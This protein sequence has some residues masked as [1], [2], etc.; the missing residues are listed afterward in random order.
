MDLPCSGNY[1]QRRRTQRHC[2]MS[3]VH[4]RES[5]VTCLLM[6]GGVVQVPQTTIHW[7]LHLSRH[8]HAR[9]RS[10]TETVCT[11]PISKRIDGYA[12]MAKVR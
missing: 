11:R 6:T 9:N 10:N 4:F 8:S 12:E 5:A 3:V 2:Y 7:T 1:K